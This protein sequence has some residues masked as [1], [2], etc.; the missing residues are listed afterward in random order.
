MQ[1]TLQKGFSSLFSLHE[2]ES[3]S[4]MILI[5]RSSGACWK[6]LNHVINF[7]ISF[8]IWA[9]FLENFCYILDTS[10]YL[11]IYIAHIN[12]LKVRT[13]VYI[14]NIG[15]LCSTKTSNDE[16]VTMSNRI[17][18]THTGHFLI[19]HQS[20]ISFFLLNFEKLLGHVFG[21]IL[22]FTQ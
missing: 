19:C 22:D 9:T 13:M 7:I 14:H 2:V 15:R 11:F 21:C 16:A 4:N 12:I 10:L 17:L 18:E 8:K 6:L 20:L 1:A 3:M 5:G